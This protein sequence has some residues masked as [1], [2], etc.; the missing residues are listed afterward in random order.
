MQM[1]NNTIYALAT[2]LGAGVA[3]VRISGPKSEPALRALF[4]HR[5]DYES[6]RLFHG[7]VIFDGE[8]IDDAMAVLM[9]APKSYTGEDVA[10][11]HIH[12]SPAVA[13]KLLAALARLGLRL[14]E[15]GEFT[16]RAFENGKLDLSAAE[17]VMDLVSA[18]AEESAKAALAQLKGSMFLAV[19][20]LQ[21]ELT[22][23]IAR[24]EAG[25]DYPEEDWESDIA[26]ELRPALEAIGAR[27]QRLIDSGAQGRCL[28]EGLR[29]VLCGRPNAGKSTLLN[30][31]VGEDRAIVTAV[32]GTTRDLIEE[33]VDWKG[34]PVR[35]IDTAGLREAADEVEQIGVG[36]ARQAIEEA[37]LLLALFDSSRPLNDEDRSVLSAVRARP[38]LAVLTKGDLPAVLSK[39]ELQELS[40]LPAVTVCAREEGGLGELEEAVS[41]FFESLAPAD[42]EQVVV[43]NRRHLDALCRAKEGVEAARAAME[44]YDLDCATI[45]LR[46]AWSALGQITGRTVD[47][48]II[49]RIFEKFC[50]GK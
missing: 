37:D 11:F 5:G 34:I 36:R 14:A 19:T 30:A 26:D 46:R 35:L 29:V 15:P 24:A 27:L 6:H 16:R 48:A 42:R 33:Q 12:G 20:A 2:P 47:S 39:D 4:S 10:E 17:A 40:G 13:K 44:Q 50:L 18:S 49:D 45:D 31:L 8:I 41:R 38:A 32:P 3:V 23:A 28:R 21:D 9:R 43:T 22:D 1:D 7:N 25:I